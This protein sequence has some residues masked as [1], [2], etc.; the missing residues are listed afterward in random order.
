MKT[1]PDE[2]GR[3]LKLGNTG[4]IPSTLAAT[5]PRALEIYHKEALSKQS[6]KLTNQISVALASSTDGD[7]I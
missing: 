4:S 1:F 7:R 6:M 5:T 3:T 2:V